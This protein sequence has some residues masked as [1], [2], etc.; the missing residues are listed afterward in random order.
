MTPILAFLVFIVVRNF[1][2]LRQS[3]LV[4]A[5]TTADI[6]PTPAEGGALAARWA[7]ISR[8]IDS[9]NEGEWKFAVIEADKLVDDV[10]K[11]G[12]FAGESMG[13]RL[14]N[15][16]KSQL[17]SLDGLWDAHKTRNRLVHDSNYFLRYA[18]AKRAVR[19]YEET[20]RELGAL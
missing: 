20:L 19:L 2:K 17:V 11:S 16:D 9:T 13:E 12:G 4:G 1:I 18:E 8:H 6:T 15:I 14:M 10:L 5:I 7:E 3:H